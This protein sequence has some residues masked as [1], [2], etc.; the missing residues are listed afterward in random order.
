MY[1]ESFSLKQAWEQTAYSFHLQQAATG[2]GILFLSYYENPNAKLSD[3]WANQT[4][5]K[6]F[7][8]KINRNS[9]LKAR[10]LF[11]IKRRGSWQ[12]YR[13]SLIWT[14]SL[15]CRMRSSKL[16]LLLSYAKGNM[17][18]HIDLLL[19]PEYNVCKRYI[20]MREDEL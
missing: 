3:F 1:S 8:T 14:A 17:I 9:S 15:N 4:H 19:A 6:L 5:K 16:V 2:P 20:P 18:A 7:L 12:C 13:N 11:P 10:P